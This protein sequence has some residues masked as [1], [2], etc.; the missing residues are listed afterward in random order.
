MGCDPNEP[1]DHN[2]GKTDTLGSREAL[3]PPLSGRFM[4]A[5]VAVVRV[6]EDVDVRQNHLIRLSDS[7]AAS[8]SSSSAS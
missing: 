4:H 7:A 1:E 3:I 6:H 2:P 5:G 8:A